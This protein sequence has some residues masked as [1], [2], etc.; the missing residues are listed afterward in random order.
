LIFL[1]ILNYKPYYNLNY[2]PEKEEIYIK[3]IVILLYSQLIIVWC[4]VYTRI[5]C[6]W[7]ATLYEYQL[8][9]INNDHRSAW[10]CRRLLK[11]YSK[12][13]ACKTLTLVWYSQCLLEQGRN[14][15][16]I[17][18]SEKL[19]PTKSVSILF[20]TPQKL[21][22]LSRLNSVN[23]A[24]T[25]IQLSDKLKI[26]GATLDSNITMESHIKALSSSCFYHIRSFKQIRSSLDYDMAI[27]VASAL[28]VSSRL[29]QVNSILYGAASK[30]TD[31]LQRVQK[32]LARIFM[33]QRSHCSP[34]SSTALL[35]N[36]HWLPIEWGIR[37]KLATL[38]YKALRLHEPVWTL[39]SSSS[40]L[41]SVPRCNFE[42]GS[43]AF[44]ISAPKIWNSLPANIRDCPS[45]PTFRRH[46]KTHYFQLAYHSPWWLPLPQCAL[47]L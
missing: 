44:R 46:L 33:H 25:D 20:G 3:D 43:R 24:G 28:Q 17:R 4:F 11:N 27:S 32:A 2:K 34:L 10:I 8:R 38:A 14:P 15:S 26:L 30:H 37:F 31:R 7:R 12:T 40:L 36:L 1:L 6:Y 45:L 41:L 42:F 13:R 35:Q 21:K 39:Q 23:V 22:S 47:I 18:K 29:D 19:N 16:L 5:W 9:L